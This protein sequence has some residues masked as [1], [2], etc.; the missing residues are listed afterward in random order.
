LDERFFAPAETKMCLRNASET[1]E[2]VTIIQLRIYV[3]DT[4]PDHSA[5]CPT[6][7][8]KVPV[9]QISSILFSATARN[10]RKKLHGSL[11][12]N[13]SKTVAA[14]Q[15][16]AHRL[17]Q[18]SIYWQRR[19]VELR[20]QTAIHLQKIVSMIACVYIVL[21]VYSMQQSTPHKPDNITTVTTTSW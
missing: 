15:M 12:L 13:S 6:Q 19:R 1:D 16:A 14:K 20:Q 5:V 11:V 4:L 2:G 9:E 7:F 3:K 8:N 17:C 21:D 10:I 18:N